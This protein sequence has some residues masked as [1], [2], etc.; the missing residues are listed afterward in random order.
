MNTKRPYKYSTSFYRRKKKYVRIL[1]STVPPSR[2]N[3]SADSTSESSVSDQQPLIN[4]PTI[5]D[6]DANI[7]PELPSGNINEDLNSE[8]RAESTSSNVPNHA[9]FKAQIREWLIDNKV[10]HLATNNLLKILTEYGVEDLPKDSRTF[11]GTARTIEITQMGDNGEYW[12][13]GLA[14]GIRNALAA[15][16]ANVDRV[17]L[18]F[19]IDGLPLFR[20]S[21][22]QFWP[23]LCL[24]DNIRESKPFI[25]GIY[26]GESKP[27]S[28]DDFFSKFVDEM[29]Q[30]LNDGI[31]INEKNIAVVIKCFICDS[32]ARAYVKGEFLFYKWTP[33]I[34]FIRA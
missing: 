20:G 5:V 22:N 12:H 15:K 32:P 26:F 2:I 31:I 25:V 33:S 19:N 27:A 21:K 34:H 28:I 24:V 8:I 3:S 7:P 6:N 23:I 18:K 1:N 9:K 4:R 30:L 14:N 11:L 17:E 10:S 16:E 29:V 13:N